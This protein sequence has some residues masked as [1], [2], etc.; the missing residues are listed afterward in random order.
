MN[1]RLSAVPDKDNPSGPAT[2]AGKN[3]KKELEILAAETLRRLIDSVDGNMVLEKQD[4]LQKR[5]FT[6]QINDILE[7]LLEEGEWQLS[8]GDKKKII[9]YVIDEVF[10]YGP[11]NVLIQDLSVT[12]I[13]INGHD[14]IYIEMKGKLVKS[15]ITFRDDDHVSH[16]INKIINPLGR[17]L[18]ESC[19][20]VDARLPDGSRVNAIIPPLSLDGPSITIRK[21]STDPF[22]MDDLVNFGTMS[23]EMADF[24]AACVRSRVNMLVSGGTGSGKTSTLN[25]LSSFIPNDERI[26]TIED[27]AELQ[28]SQDNIVRLESRSANVEG[29][30]EFSIRQLV[31]N[32]LRMR[33]DRIVVGEVRGGEALD[34]LQAMNTGHDG[35]ISTLHANSPRDALARLETMVLMA[36]VELPLRSIREQIAST[37]NIILH[38]S[39]LSDG[40]RKIT[41]ISELVGIE[42]DTIKL[43]DIFHFKQEGLGEEG[44]VLGELLPTGVTPLAINQLKA[45]GEKF[46]MAAVPGFEEAEN[47]L[48]AAARQPLAE[49]PPLMQEA[50]VQQDNPSPE[51]ESSSNINLVKTGQEVIEKDLSQNNFTEAPGNEKMLRLVQKQSETSESSLARK[52]PRGMRGIALVVSSPPALFRFLQPGD[53]VDILAFSPGRLEGQLSCSTLERAVF[54]AVDNTGDTYEEEQATTFFLAVTP[55]QARTLSCTR[56]ADSLHLTLRPSKEES[57]Q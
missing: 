54:L 10:G 38:Q 50:S 20:T 14:N 1:F 31:I 2:E 42:G 57:A 17:R 4:S 40:S 18:D 23:P 21:F 7:G 52:V 49:D 19:P 35:S 46:E 9:Q 47:T 37:V 24:L 43:Q 3:K 45:F 16:T 8:Q 13:M 34:M 56:P 15:E 39:R 53:E 30:G 51:K 12:E 28:L 33:P 27:T 26:V 55:D 11:I 36:G 48:P 32:A 25:V 29:K 44:N 5:Q 22:T 6:D 41:R